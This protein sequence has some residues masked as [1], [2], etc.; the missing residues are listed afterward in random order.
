MAP[1][2]KRIPRLNKEKSV[3]NKAAGEVFEELISFERVLE[4]RQDLDK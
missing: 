2:P 4:T 1:R 3:R